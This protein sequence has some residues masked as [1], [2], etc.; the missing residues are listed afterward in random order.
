MTQAVATIK[1]WIWGLDGIEDRGASGKIQSL[2]D[3]LDD[4]TGRVKF[5]YYAMW[6]VVSAVAI[7][8]LGYLFFTLIPQLIGHLAKAGV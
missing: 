1:H 4:L 3:K 7:S 6:V 2:D 5:I 8:G